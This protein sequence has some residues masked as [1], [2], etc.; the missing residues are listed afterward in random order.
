MKQILTA[1]FRTVLRR[2]RSLFPRNDAETLSFRI[3]N[4]P[5][6]SVTFVLSVFHP[7]R[8]FAIVA[9]FELFTIIP[10]SPPVTKAGLRVIKSSHQ[11]ISFSFGMPE[12]YF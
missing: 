6:Q 5:R 2:G 8:Q 9:S 12:T 7:H 11:V 3:Y 10:T 4:H 1:E